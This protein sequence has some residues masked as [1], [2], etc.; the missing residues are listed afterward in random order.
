MQVVSVRFHQIKETTYRL[1]KI[2]LDCQPR[3]L[4]IDLKRH[5][6]FSWKT[7]FFFFLFERYII[8]STKIVTTLVVSTRV[9]YT[10]KSVNDHLPRRFVSNSSSHSKT[11]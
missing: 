6:R 8:E 4:Q 2:S 3:S 7:V 1:V 10:D 11:C 5:T 9:P